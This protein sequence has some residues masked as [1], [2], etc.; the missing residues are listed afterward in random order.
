MTVEDTVPR[1]EMDGRAPTYMPFFSRMAPIYP[2]EACDMTSKTPC[3]VQATVYS[4]FPPPFSCAHLL[5]EKGHLKHAR[6]PGNEEV[7]GGG[8]QGRESWI[9]RQGFRVHSARH[10]KGCVLC[11]LV[12]ARL[13]AR[14]EHY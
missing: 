14:V 1:G 13:L 4:S 7:R 11:P 10:E 9:T 2:F 3:P 6:R 12:S 5:F 8:L